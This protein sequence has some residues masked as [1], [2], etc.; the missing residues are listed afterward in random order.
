MHSSRSDKAFWPFETV[1]FPGRLSHNSSKTAAQTA[2]HD[3]TCVSSSAEE[4]EASKPVIAKQSAVTQRALAL[5]HSFAMIYALHA[6][7]KFLSISLLASMG[8]LILRASFVVGRRNLY[9][10][11]SP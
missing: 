7:F 4:H 9:D 1:S 2:R 8:F 6:L 10:I 11:T 3:R 5:V